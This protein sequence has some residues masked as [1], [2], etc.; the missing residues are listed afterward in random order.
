MYNESAIAES[1]PVHSFGEAHLQEGQGPKR[2][3]VV[4]PDAALGLFLKRELRLKGFDVELCRDGEQALQ[5]VR[6]AEYALILQDL[7]LPKMD[8]MSLLHAFS[9][10]CPQ[11]PV[12]VL[13][14]R[15]RTEDLVRA[16]DWGAHD[17]LVKPFSLLELQ[18]RM[19]NLLRRASMPAPAPGSPA[20]GTQ[21][22]INKQERRVT[23][24]G[25]KIDLTPREF[26]LLEHL[27]DNQGKAVSRATLMQDVWNAPFEP[28]N[29]IVDVYMKYLRD[30]I[31]GEGEPKLIRTI[32]GVGY[33]LDPAASA[34]QRD[35][36][37]T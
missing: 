32:R 19:R 28:S 31:D 37:W 33:M 12:V 34:E 36:L 9:T 35:L 18:A 5:E 27:V 25:R 8:G 7:N 30:K 21:L 23:R 24:G 14:A 20:R 13:T 11:I 4:E 1:A 3:L 26:A 22:A 2:V 6:A 17:Y 29:N 10:E 15:S 16:L